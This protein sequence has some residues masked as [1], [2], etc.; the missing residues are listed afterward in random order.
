M[1]TAVHWANAKGLEKAIAVVA[2]KLLIS[3]L[4]FIFSPKHCVN[5]FAL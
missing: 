5:D 1:S 2:N 4:I 3:F